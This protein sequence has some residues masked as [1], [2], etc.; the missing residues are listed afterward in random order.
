[1]K[2]NSYSFGSITID[3]KIYQKD[4]IVFPEKIHPDWTRIKG[5]SLELADIKDIIDYH[6]ETLIIGTGAYGLMTIPSSTSEA[7]RK[8][9]IRLIA[10][11]TKKACS[12]FNEHLI[13]NTKTVGAF[14]LTC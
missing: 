9:K 11:V 6:P 10:E 2:I 13:N 4:I 7:L 14:H 5:H 1:M 3:N 8:N 12:I